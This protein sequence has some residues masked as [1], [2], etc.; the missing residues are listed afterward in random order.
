MKKVSLFMAVVGMIVIITSCG[1]K[2]SSNMTN[3]FKKLIAKH[4]SMVIPLNKEASLAYFNASISGKEEDFKKVLDLQNKITAIYSNKEDF[5]MLKKIKESK[6]IKDEV[7]ARQLEVMY[8]MY[9]GN[10]VDT[11]MLN[12]INTMQNGI[13]QKYSNFRAD[14][15]GKK[16]SDNDVEGILKTSTNSKELEAAWLG[17]KAVGP[18]VAKD[19]IALVKKRNEMAKKLGFKNYHE[20][21]LNLSEQDP[22]EIEK[23]FD[24]LDNLTRD[25]FVAL[26]SEMDDYFAKRYKIK[27]EELKPW[28]Y[29]NRFFQEAPRIYTVD[30]DKYYKT[31]DVVKVTESFF[32]GVGLPIEDVIKN[33]DLF[34]K[35]GKNQHAYCIDIDN[36]GDV[37]V[38]CNVRNNENW[39]GTMLHEFGH[40]SY[41][42]YIDNKNLPY[43]L[44]N[45][46]H[47]FTTEAI[48]MFFGRLSTNAQW[49]KDNIG[50]S[51]KDAKEIA[52]IGFKQ[53]RLQQIVFSRWSQVMYRFEKGLYEN[54]DQDLNN[55]WWTLVEKYQ[56]IK[57]PEG[58]NEPDW[59]SK[60]HIATSPCYYHNY[61]MGE[62]LA[63][64]F[65]YYIAKNI[66][67]SEDIKNLKISG[68]AEIGKYFID[69]VFKPG[70]KYKWN[71]MIEKAT[72]EKLTPKYY[73]KQFVESK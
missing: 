41:D 26:K 23:L 22:T 37:R 2:K 60:I 1:N 9:H 65:T 66:L 64:Q 33:S 67:K 28:H 24:E 27:K 63:S 10:Q 68:N 43:V 35:P 70:A 46:A 36:E 59:A 8:N 51:E 7:L 58:R 62:L 54:P 12:Q 29:Q 57:K 21:S 40:A 72:G 38:L 4:D 49:M 39:M 50:L 52:E 32:K 44:R 48:A 73:A 13:E 25:A 69:K 16:I 53:L 55:L 45:P 42:K 19:I 61:H 71:D 20:M 31:Q 30:F 47:T 11:A 3:D 34:E 5:A 14:V 15:N 6:E 18:V 56:L 17:H